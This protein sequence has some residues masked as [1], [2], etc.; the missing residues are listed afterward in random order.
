MGKKEKSRRRE[1][2]VSSLQTRKRKLSLQEMSRCHPRVQQGSHT[3]CLPH[4][5]Y[6]QLKKEK[7]GCKDDEEHCLL[8]KSTRLSKLQKDTLRK[9]YLRPIQPN[10]WDKDPDAWL[11]NFNI[12]H[13]LTQYHEAYPWFKFL[14]VFPIDFSA[15][16]PYLKNGG[17]PKCLHRELCE[18]SLQAEYDAGCRG[19]GIIFNL[20]PHYK[21]G[22]HWVA[23]YINLWNIQKPVISYFDSYGYET[24]K[25][26]ARLMRSFTLQIPTCELGYNARRFQYSNTECGMFSTYF[27]ICMISGISFEQF[28]KDVVDDAFMLKLRRILFRK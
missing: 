22:S 14:G 21:S 17:P 9:H 5:I 20:D 6:Q 28:C 25:L 23:L 19:I 16:D 3:H 4:T 11:D 15:P 12:M 26:I 1:S 27:I 7:N 8:D 2:S 24:P 13:V 18:L 10:E